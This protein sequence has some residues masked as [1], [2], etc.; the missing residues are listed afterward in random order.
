M[1]VAV[2]ATAPRGG[3]DRHREQ[4]DDHQPPWADPYRDAGDTPKLERTAWLDRGCR[5]A[6]RLPSVIRGASER[7]FT[8]I[9]RT[10]LTTFHPVGVTAVLGELENPS[11]SEAVAA[12]RARVGEFPDDGTLN[13]DLCM[14]AARIA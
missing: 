5:A 3:C 2:R 1:Y 11:T 13:D 4:G 7:G 14:L 10:A 12:L 8:Q 9:T 6:P